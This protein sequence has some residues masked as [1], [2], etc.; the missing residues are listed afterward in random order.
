[1][2]KNNFGHNI[3]FPT[4][5]FTLPIWTSS[6]PLEANIGASIV[7][8]K[9]VIQTVNILER[10]RILK[11]FRRG[12]NMMVDFITSEPG[13]Q[14]LAMD[15]AGSHFSL[16]GGG[17]SVGRSCESCEKLIKTPSAPNPLNLVLGWDSDIHAFLHWHAFALLHLPRF[18]KIETWKPN[19]YL[20]RA[21]FDGN[22]DAHRLHHNFYL[23]LFD[24][25]RHLEDQNDIGSKVFLS[26]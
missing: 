25:F 11:V 14:Q 9:T 17:H 7:A 21:I 6:R 4:H 20:F 2:Y 10:K 12:T 13:D 5:R 18:K 15:V 19:F 8:A 22:W 26:T 24:D 23:W 1:M 3:I 16:D